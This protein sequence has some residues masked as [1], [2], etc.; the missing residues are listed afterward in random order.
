[1]PAV[2][3]LAARGGL[4]LAISVGLLSAESEGT[5]F[6]RVADPSGRA[7]QN[8]NVVLRNSATHLERTVTTNDEGLFEL[9]ALPVGSYRLQV[10]ALGFRLYT[11]EAITVEVA[12][13]VDLYVRLEIGELSEEVTVGSQTTPIDCGTTTV[14]HIIDGRTVQDMP[15]NGRYFLDLA[16]LAPGSVT[17]SQNGFNSAPSRGLGAFSIITAG[18]RDST[19]NYLINGI[20]L[21]NLL[22]GGIT[23]QPSISTVQEFKIDN[24]TLSAE[25]GQS[26]GASVNLATRSGTSEFHGEVFEFLRNSALDAR[27]FFTLTSRETLPFKRNQFGGNLGGPIARGKTFFFGYYE[28]MRQS[29]QIDLNSLVLSDAQRQ[30][31]GGAAIAKLV[32]LIPRSNFTDSAGTPRFVGSGPAPVDADQWGAAR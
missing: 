9:P 4:L 6:G 10:R 19:T 31:A 8:A 15:L 17:S 5:L 32:A 24:S 20:T 22:Y 14:G 3:G 11:V 30:S 13:T 7:V 12:R 27:N 21:N 1:M 29:Q 18:N 26:S 16:V 28:G 2:L 25:Y 23:Y